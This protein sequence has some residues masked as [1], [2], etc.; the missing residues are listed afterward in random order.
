MLFHLRSPTLAK[1]KRVPASL[2]RIVRVFLTALA[3]PINLLCAREKIH[4]HQV[5]YTARSASPASNSRFSC[6]Y[7]T[8]S[9]RYSS[10]SLRRASGGDADR[11]ADCSLL[12]AHSRD[13]QD[14]KDRKKGFKMPKFRSNCPQRI[15]ARRRRAPPGFQFMMSGCSLETARFSI[16]LLMRLARRLPHQHFTL[17]GQ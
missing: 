5:I 6:G 13:S 3:R 11:D 4:L 7:S 15:R 17:P 12:V 8:T 10:A 14:K 1:I 2:R 9:P 16:Y